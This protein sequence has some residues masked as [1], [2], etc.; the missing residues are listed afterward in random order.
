MPNIYM[1]Y[2]LRRVLFDLIFS[3]KYDLKLICKNSIADFQDFLEIIDSSGI[4]C[5]SP[6]NHQHTPCKIECLLKLDNSRLMRY[7]KTRKAS[8]YS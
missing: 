3:V 4:T 2:R 8:S 7:I 5:Q 6:E 1:A